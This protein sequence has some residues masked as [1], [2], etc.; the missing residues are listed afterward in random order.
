[1]KSHGKIMLIDDAV[2]V[3]GSLALAPLSLDFRREVAILV[4]EAPG[5]CRRAATVAA[6]DAAPTEGGTAPQPGEALC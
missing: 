5:H 2:A 6:I 3:V 1:L 4:D